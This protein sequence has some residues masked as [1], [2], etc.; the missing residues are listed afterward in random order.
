MVVTFE[1]FVAACDTEKV[2]LHD[3][4]REAGE[5]GYSSTRSLVYEPTPVLAAIVES[6]TVLREGPGTSLAQKKLV[7]SYRYD[8][9]AQ[10]LR[11]II[12]TSICPSTQ[13]D[14]PSFHCG[15]VTGVSTCEI[16]DE[17]FACL[18]DNLYDG[19]LWGG[20]EVFCHNGRP[21]LLRKSRNYGYPSALTLT[22]TV[23]NGVTYP[24]GMLAYT[25]ARGDRLDPKGWPIVDMETAAVRDAAEVMASGM[26]R[27][28]SLGVPRNRRTKHFP[29]LSSLERYMTAAYIKKALAKVLAAV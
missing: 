25:Q 22:K 27:L 6:C 28:S 11:R 29:Y 17:Q 7:T 5:K 19:W 13:P 12:N 2:G 23:V 1:Q 4:V 10:T 18:I 3:A 24:A 8:M 26:V 15:K 9:P 21:V 14:L 16:A 20:C